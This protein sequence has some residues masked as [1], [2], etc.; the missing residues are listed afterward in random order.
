MYHPFMQIDEQNIFYSYDN[1]YFFTIFVPKNDNGEGVEDA[2]GE[3]HGEAAD[4]RR[5]GEVRCVVLV[6]RYCALW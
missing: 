4:T 3:D 6:E 1:R 5:I 2:D